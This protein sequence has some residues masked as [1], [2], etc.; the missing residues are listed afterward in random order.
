MREARNPQACMLYLE[1]GLFWT[2]C[3]APIGLRLC[4][5]TMGLEMRDSLARPKH[6]ASPVHPRCAELMRLVKGRVSVGSILR[7]TKGWLRA[8][9]VE[10]DPQRRQ[11][12]EG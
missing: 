4:L 10:E 11:T 12:D 6:E 5:A 8:P 3:R 9:V 2:G 7:L 1:C